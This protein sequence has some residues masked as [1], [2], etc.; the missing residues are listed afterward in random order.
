MLSNETVASLFK[1]CMEFTLSSKMFNRRT[2]ELHRVGV[3]AQVLAAQSEDAGAVL[4]VLVREI[5]TLTS[6]TSKVL[7]QIGVGGELLAKN[8]IQA[9][10]SAQLLQIYGRTLE[11]GLKGETLGLLLRVVECEDTK[12]RE[13]LL[14]IQREL[15]QYRVKL[16]ELQSS[17]LFIPALIRLININVADYEEFRG[18]FGA[19]TI[20]LDSFKTVILDSTESMISGISESIDTIDI[21]S[22]ES[23]HD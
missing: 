8:S 15:R 20:E 1:N 9:T 11:L 14:N 6:D 21:I 17:I 4:G 5:G 13:R 10:R 16:K 7:E 2:A 22:L 23:K 19:I 12:L 3:N 18:Q